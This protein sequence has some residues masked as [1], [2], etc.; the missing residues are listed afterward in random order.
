MKVELWVAIY[1]AVMGTIASGIATAHVIW[2]LFHDRANLDVKGQIS[3]VHTDRM[4]VILRISA[5][6]NGRRP[7]SVRSVAAFLAKESLPIPQGVSPDRSAEV[8]ELNQAK[9]ISHQLNIFGGRGEKPFQLDPDGG[10]QTWDIHLYKRVQFQKHTKGNEE[11]GMACVELTSG[12][13]V[14]CDFLIP[15]DEHWPSA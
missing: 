5:V 12:K 3:F 8:L 14:L 7:V 4:R 9:L 10:E 15:K 13:K 2:Q 1:G 6:N 11:L